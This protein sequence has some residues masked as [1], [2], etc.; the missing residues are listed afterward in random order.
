[1]TARM[2]KTLF[3]ATDLKQLTD[4]QLQTLSRNEE[5]ALQLENVAHVI[6]GIGLLVNQH[7]APGS[8]RAGSFEES[9]SLS[10]LLF[11]FSNQ[12][13]GLSEAVYVANEADFVINERKL[14]AAI[15]S[16]AMTKATASVPA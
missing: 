10:T 3:E 2:M 15:A 5:I 8:M 16:A 9:G 13:A 7:L 6:E 4:D 11:A 12:I 14:A 1:M